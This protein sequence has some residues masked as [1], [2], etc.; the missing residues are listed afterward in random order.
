MA[1]THKRTLR[2]L[3]LIVGG[4]LSGIF[5]FVAIVLVVGPVGASGEPNA[6]LQWG[7]L[8]AAGA[9]LIVHTVALRLVD[10]RVGAQLAARRTDALAELQ[11]DDVPAELYVRT[12]FA[13]AF[14]ESIA[15]LGPILYLLTGSSYAAAPLAV[16][17]VW[18]GLQFPSHERLRTA[19]ERAGRPS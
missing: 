4:L 17:R 2:L 18:M 11:R 12:L 5:L 15:L 8:G 1:R 6:A 9:L 13:V 16:G 3:Q 14:G 10:A 19:I 7:L